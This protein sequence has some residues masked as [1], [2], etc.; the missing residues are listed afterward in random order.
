[1]WDKSR[2]HDL[3]GGEFWEVVFDYRPFVNFGDSIILQTGRA[4]T[5]GLFHDIGGRRFTT[6]NMNLGS[7]SITMTKLGGVVS[8]LHI[9]WERQYSRIHVQLDPRIARM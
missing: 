7:Y 1:M 9:A 4:T 3:Y 8:G 6:Y 2:F 5:R